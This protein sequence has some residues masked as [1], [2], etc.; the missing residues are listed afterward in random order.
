MVKKLL[1]S[2][3]FLI[4]IF[5]IEYW[6]VV[7]FKTLVDVLVLIIVCLFIPVIVTKRLKECKKL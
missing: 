2:L 1:L 3:Y 7:G 5:F 4:A 6:R